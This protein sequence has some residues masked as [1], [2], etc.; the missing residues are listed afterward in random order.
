[1]IFAMA[2]PGLANGLIFWFGLIGLGYYN[3]LVRHN[4]KGDSLRPAWRR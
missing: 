3:S 1:L 4:P 2:K